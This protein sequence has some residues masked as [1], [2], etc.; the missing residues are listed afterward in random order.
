MVGTT[1]FIAG[2][3]IFDIVAICGFIFKAIVWFIDDGLNFA[4]F[5]FLAI[6]LLLI[7]VDLLLLGL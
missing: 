3:V 2:L 6:A 4:S 5:E 1:I 7:G